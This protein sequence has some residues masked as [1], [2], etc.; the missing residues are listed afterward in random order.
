MDND[1]TAA[2]DILQPLGPTKRVED[3]LIEENKSA[4]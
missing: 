1:S 3:I 4:S 2:L